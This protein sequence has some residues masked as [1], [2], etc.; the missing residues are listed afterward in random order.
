MRLLQSDSSYITFAD[1]FE[2]YCEEHG[3]GRE[4]PVFLIGEKLKAAMREIRE[5]KDRSVCYDHLRR[6]VEADIT[7]A[8]E[9]GIDELEERLHGRDSPQTRARGRHLEGTLTRQQVKFL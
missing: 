5:T 8:Y 1:I 7:A 6:L 9:D 3:V 2:Q 4:D